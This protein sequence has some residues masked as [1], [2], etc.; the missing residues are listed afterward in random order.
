MKTRRLMI[1]GLDAATLDLIHPWCEGGHLPNI[2]RFIEQGTVAPL[3]S[4]LPVQSPAAW[5]TFATGT[6]PG[7]HGVLNFAQL[8]SDSYD[9]VFMNASHRRGTTFWEIAGEQGIR[10]GV[11]NIPFTYPP[12]PF[13]GFMIT[14]MLSPAV[15]RRLAYPEEILNDL[16]EVSPNYAIDVN[17][18]RREDDAVRE[19][20][21][22]RA[23][24]AVENR[25][26]TAV[27]LFRRHRPP[28]FC[29]AYT[30]S[31][32]VS[33]YYWNDLLAARKNPEDPHGF[34]SPIGT[35][36]KKMDDGIGE[37]LSEAGPETD[38]LLLSDH[39][40][41]NL[42]K[43][44]SMRKLLARAGLM[45]EATPGA[46]KRIIKSSLLRF[47]RTCP[48]TLRQR[49]QDVM[50]GLSSKAVSQIASGGIDFAGSQAYPTEGVE[51]VFVNLRGRQPNGIVSPGEEYE[52]VRDRV[53]QLFTEITD[54]ETGDHV[55]KGAYRREDVWNGPR[56]ETLPDVVLEQKSWMYDTKLTS[57][58]YGTDVFCPLPRAGRP[59]LH[60]TGRH[61]RLGMFMGMG[62]HV[63][64]TS[65]PPVEM[66]DVPATI[67]ALL[68]LPVP[69]HFDGR[70]LRE[71]LTNDIEIAGRTAVKDSSDDA[72]QDF[73][74]DEQSAV[75]ERLKGLG[76]L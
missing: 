21:F 45:K 62:P 19:E 69:K 20:F 49:I 5:S 60:D 54:P 24:A 44:F 4:T 30:A 16:R 13:N 12:R 28:L 3:R 37:L 63:Q 73:S 72:G 22:R 38:V 2:K 71:M 34:R 7:K 65:L 9:A 58:A 1:I 57:A 23:V 43:V 17:I 76:Y 35:I 46:L 14:G 48:R 8:R 39:G 36:Y 27:G 47:A 33:H 40:A 25:T 15:D 56:I 26:K 51:G 70:V 50:P 74:A 67:L 29:T 68:G 10:G 61:H 32:R 75:E 55:F 59:G 52:A 53:I 41:G 42:A 66:A 6:N 11:I 18:V 31:D 64:R